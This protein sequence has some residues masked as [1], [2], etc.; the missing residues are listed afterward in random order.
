MFNNI[1]TAEIIIIIFVLIFLFGGNK[2]SEIA[3]G[4]G[5]ATREVKKAQKEI[6][7]VTEDLKK[8]VVVKKKKQ[9]S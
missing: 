5:E 8:E 2:I 1:G 7:N 3:K 9:K 4:L 6:E